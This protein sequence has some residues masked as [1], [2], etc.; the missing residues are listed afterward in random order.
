MLLRK[1]DLNN[2]KKNA[3]NENKDAI[4][5]AVKFFNPTGAA[6]W[7]IS[8]I[9]EDGDTLFG[10]CDMGHGTPELGYVSLTEIKTF[11]GR[12]GRG[13]ERDRSFTA[14]MSLADYADEARNA[15][16]INA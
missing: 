7:L 5:P 4:R 16:R 2:L 12:F 13:I 9:M 3:A 15:G 1:T 8:E 14:D 10:L 6:T 11:R